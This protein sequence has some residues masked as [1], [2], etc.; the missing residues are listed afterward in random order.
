M[1]VAIHRKGDKIFTNA[2]LGLSVFRSFTI[3]ITTALGLVGPKP[4][5]FN[6]PDVSRWELISMIPEFWYKFQVVERVST[7]KIVETL[8]VHKHFLVQIN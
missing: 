8:P 2:L 6:T 3:Y 7:D 5:S 4:F 1:W